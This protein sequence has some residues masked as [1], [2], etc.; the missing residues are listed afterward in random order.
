[1]NPEDEFL[2]GKKVEDEDSETS[3]KDKCPNCGRRIN[4]RVKSCSCG[5]VFG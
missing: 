4:N 5:M 3:G 2:W 1:M